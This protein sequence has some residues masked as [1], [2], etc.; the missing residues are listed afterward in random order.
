[1]I[2]DS[3]FLIDYWNT[4]F[5]A[6]LDHDHGAGIGRHHMDYIGFL[7]F[8]ELHA[9]PVMPSRQSR[10]NLQRSLSNKAL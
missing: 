1:M 2:G 5:V 10:N 3:E 4:R 6:R 7:T 9:T 8:N